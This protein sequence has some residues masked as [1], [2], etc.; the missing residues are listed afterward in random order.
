VEF[1]YMTDDEIE[2]KLSQ[3]EKM[4]IFEASEQWKIFDVACKRVAEKAKMDLVQTSPSDTVRIIELQQIIK[5]YSSVFRGLINSFKQEGEVAYY[6]AENRGLTKQT[7]G[8]NP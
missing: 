5:L 6:E 8:S 7:S 3:W 4:E 2:A 1:E